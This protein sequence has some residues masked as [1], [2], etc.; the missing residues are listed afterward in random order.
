[1]HMRRWGAV[2][3]LVAMFLGS[4][5]G[6]YAFQVVEGDGWNLFLS[7]TFEN[8]QSEFLQL[9]V[10]GILIVGLANKMFRVSKDDM[11]RL[12]SKID[13]LLKR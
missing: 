1:M 8:W 10:Q 13:D 4:W 7:A 2:Y 9:A 11:Q 5:V 6:Q 12:E 3:L